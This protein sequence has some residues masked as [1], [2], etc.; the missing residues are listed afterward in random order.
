MEEIWNNTRC[1]SAIVKLV[2]DIINKEIKN[3]QLSL[4]MKEIYDEEWCKH[5]LEIIKNIGNIL[6]L[7]KLL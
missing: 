6:V 7:T 1:M 5:M 2:D 4:Q 3:K